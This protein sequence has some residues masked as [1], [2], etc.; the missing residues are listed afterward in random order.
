VSAER[1]LDGRG[2]LSE[3]RGGLLAREDGAD[4]GVLVAEVLEPL[5]E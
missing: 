2:A 3:I 5:G 4:A 1:H